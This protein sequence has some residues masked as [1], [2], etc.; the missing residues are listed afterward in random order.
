MPEILFSPVEWQKKIR[1][2]TQG[3]EKLSGAFAAA[4]ALVAKF[5]TTSAEK[6]D[7][8]IGVLEQIKVQAIVG[9]CVTPAMSR[10]G[11]LLIELCT[12]A[13][14][15]KAVIE[16]SVAAWKILRESRLGFRKG[17]A[18]ANIN[19]LQDSRPGLSS[20]LMPQPGIGGGVI[21]QFAPV[22][23]KNLAGL[24][25]LLEKWDPQHRFFHN[26]DELDHLF[27]E[28]RTD[29]HTSLGFIAWL[30]RKGDASALP[31]VKYLEPSGRWR[32]KCYFQKSPDDKSGNSPARGRIHQYRNTIGGE[33]VKGQYLELSPTFTAHNE[34]F[35]EEGTA[36]WVCDEDGNF[37]SGSSEIGEF[38]HSTFL[39]GQKIIAGGEWYLVNGKVLL[40]SNS[41]GHYKPTRHQLFNALRILGVQVDLSKTIVKLEIE[42]HH[43]PYEEFMRTGGNPA[44]VYSAEAEVGKKA[45]L[46]SQNKRE[47]FTLPPDSAKLEET[48]YYGTKPPVRFHPRSSNRPDGRVPFPTPSPTPII[49]PTPTPTP[50]SIP[51][52]S[53][54]R[55]VAFHPR[56]PKR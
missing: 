46:A 24:S 51:V 34:V 5:W 56:P 36:I 1:L 21:R 27:A 55:Y 35:G 53:P 25:G 8:R 26:F 32:Y 43:V 20:V 18:I 3:E 16:K 39:A 19:K 2:Q 45:L 15:Q 54:R 40:I 37:F 6:T 52:E 9:L 4:S 48:S 28:W 30:N 14:K 22:T 13:D 10:T 7:E 38:H 17:A 31:S 23:T 50:A 44:L 41:S 11:L 33:G 42:D 29:I 12:Q 47:D 49:V